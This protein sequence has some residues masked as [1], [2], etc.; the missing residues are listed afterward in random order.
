LEDGTAI[1]SADEAKLVYETLYSIAV[2][3]ANVVPWRQATDL[4]KAAWQ[5]LSLK[6]MHNTTNPFGGDIAWTVPM[7]NGKLIEIPD[8]AGNNGL[9]D[10]NGD[11][12]WTNWIIAHELAHSWDFRGTNLSKY[13][14]G[15]N[16]GPLSEGLVKA[17]GADAKSGCLT[18]LFCFGYFAGQEEPVGGR[19]WEGARSPVEDWASSFA[20][21][22]APRPRYRLGQQRENYVKLQIQLLVADLQ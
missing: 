11:I 6:R 19:D 12:Q 2:E 18:L 5:G 8:R 14:G 9:W 22:V 4:M 7:I 21:F 13:F 10:W 17:V 1:W 15:Y 16:G 3:F 20:Q